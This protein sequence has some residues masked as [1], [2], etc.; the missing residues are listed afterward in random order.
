ML[1]NRIILILFVLE[2]GI[3]QNEFFLLM[4]LMIYY[5]NYKT[6]EKAASE[7]NIRQTATPFHKLDDDTKKLR[8]HVLQLSN[9]HSQLQASTNKLKVKVL[10]VGLIVFLLI[11]ELKF[12]L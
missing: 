7:A 1:F 8:Q 12:H 2:K 5:R 10:E 3:K 4:Y 6:T 9:K 11:S